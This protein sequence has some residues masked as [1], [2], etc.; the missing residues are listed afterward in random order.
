ML[1]LN[2]GVQPRLEDGLQSPAPAGAKHTGS[3]LS[4]PVLSRE[5]DRPTDRFTECWRARR[6]S[7][8]CARLPDLRGPVQGQASVSE[9]KEWRWAPHPWGTDPFRSQKIR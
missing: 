5:I 7:D 2:L 1:V 9:S 4:T 6:S 8:S 3:S